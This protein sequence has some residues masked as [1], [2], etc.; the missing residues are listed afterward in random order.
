[1]KVMT[2]KY[3]LLQLPEGA[4]RKVTIDAK[5]AKRGLK[6]GQEV[7]AFRNDE[8]CDF[9]LSVP[10]DSTMAKHGVVDKQVIK[11]HVLDGVIMQHLKKGKIT[12]LHP[13]PERKT[14]NAN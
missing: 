8:T 6:E 11:V 5:G 2:K 4:G 14:N 9:E 10:E 1:M 13:L 12:K 7:T 3:G